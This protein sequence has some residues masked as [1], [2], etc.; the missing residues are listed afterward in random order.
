MARDESQPH[1][2]WV[3]FLRLNDRHDGPVPISRG[4]GLQLSP[5]A[6]L[7][8][9]PTRQEP[10]H[11]QRSL[12]SVGRRSRRRRLILRVGA[13]GVVTSSELGEES[14]LPRLLCGS[15]LLL[16][17]LLRSATVFAQADVLEF[18]LL[19]GRFG[20]VEAALGEGG[21]G[22]VATGEAG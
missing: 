9:S 2:S 5:L 11:G 22:V 18:L 17:L 14:P 19:S 10:C 15:G 8:A 21:A 12:G 1:S 3:R 6:A 16:L 13:G 7:R 20:A 4:H